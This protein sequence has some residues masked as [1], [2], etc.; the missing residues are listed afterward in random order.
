MIMMDREMLDLNPSDN[1]DALRAMNHDPLVI[2]GTR[3]D[4]LYGMSDLMD[5]AV[6]VQDISVR[7]LILYGA[8]DDVIPR[9]PT[10]QWLASLVAG[11]GDP[12]LVLIYKQ[13]YH[14]LTRDLQGERV[15][16]D[17]A[18]WIDGNRRPPEEGGENLSLEKFCAQAKVPAT[19]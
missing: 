16:D 17:I 19:F 2:K 6:A 5:Q 14:M 13:G 9:Q 7:T 4:V 3:V 8:N 1:I 12:P 11:K 15:M 10:C 18:G